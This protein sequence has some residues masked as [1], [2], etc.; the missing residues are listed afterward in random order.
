LTEKGTCFSYAHR[1]GGFALTISPPRLSKSRVQSGAQCSLKLWYDC[2]ERELA[3][4]VDEI[5]QF[6]FDR[7]T[8]IGE[9][10]QERYPSGKL[11]DAQYYETDLA[12]EQTNEA[13]SDPTVSALFEPAFIHHN[14]SARIDVLQRVEADS[15]DLIEVKSAANAKDVYLRDLAIQLW[16]VQGAGLNV[17]R[18]GLLL[19]NKEY[20]YDGKHLDVGQLFT[21]VDLTSEALALRGEIQALV[22]SLHEVLSRDAAP[23][24]EPGTHC[25]VPYD[26]PYYA[27]CTKDS[28]SLEH[29]VGTLPRI[30]A[31]KLSQLDKLGVEEIND[32]PADFALNAAQARIRECVVAG[33]DWVSD[34]L[35]GALADI[36]YPVYHLDF[37]TFMPGIPVYTGTRPFEQVPFLYSIHRETQSEVVEHFE[38]LC[39]GGDDPHRELAERLV[40][41]LG[42]RGSI[43]VYSSFERTMIKALARRLPDLAPALEALVDRIWDVLP[44]IRSHY[45]HPAFQG[46]F[47]IKAVLPALVPGRDYED[48]EIGGGMAAA[49]KYEMA[50]KSADKEEREGTFDDLRAYCRLDTLAMVEL[51]RALARKVQ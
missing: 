12:V 19:L 50:L 27:H 46:S 14:V 25:S 29:P 5:L 34:G 23:Q 40:A 15:W 41:D 38:H 37:E 22:D 42:D 51:R 39:R 49:I 11:I 20:V 47:S 13:I 6:I 3:E 9:C 21:F 4:P 17:R 28:V 10:A 44:I 30:S 1:T 24:I 45:Y 36:I 8:H 7:G 16:I 48:L 26:C 2:F 43:C 31:Q 32:I 18:A 33:K 35:G